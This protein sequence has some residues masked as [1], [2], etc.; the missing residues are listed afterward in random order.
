M[1]LQQTRSAFMHW[2]GVMLEITPELR[3]SIEATL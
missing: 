1:L 3:H 2:S